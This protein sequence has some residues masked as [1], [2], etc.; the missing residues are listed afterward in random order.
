MTL[1]PW[2]GVVTRVDSAGRPFVRVPALTGTGEYGPLLRV[3]DRVEVTVPD[4]R[5]GGVTVFGAPV[6]RAGD[7]VLVTDVA[8]R[9]AVFVA[10]GRVE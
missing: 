10:L 3:R 8:G 5:G 2:L 7:D 9:P 4:G 1:G 6:Y